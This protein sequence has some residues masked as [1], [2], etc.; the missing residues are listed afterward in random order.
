M[1]KERKGESVSLYLEKDL[2]E[3]LETQAGELK[4][5]KSEIVNRL[6]LNDM[7]QETRGGEEPFS[8]QP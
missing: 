2:N 3:Y 1:A 8:N 6:L 5:S 4:V 7:L